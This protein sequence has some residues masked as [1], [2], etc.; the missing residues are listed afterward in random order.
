[1]AM[2]MSVRK[3]GFFIA[4]LAQLVFCLPVLA[5]VHFDDELKDRIDALVTSKVPWTGY[6]PSYSILIDQ[7]GQT[8]Y[9]RNIGYADIGNRIPATHD[10]VY[11]VGSITKS[12][13]ALAILQLVE[14]GQIDLDANISKYL[15]DLQGVSANA[16]V[17]QL[18]TH[19]S[20]ITNYTALPEARSIMTWKVT[21]RDDIVDLF[22]GKALDFEAGTQYSY[23]NSGYYLLGL[24]IESVS[25]QD[26]FEYLQEQVFD[27]L[28]LEATYSGAYDEI[29]PHQARGYVVTEDGFANADPTSK[30]TPFSAGILEASAADLVKYRRAVFNSEATSAELLEL[31]TTTE[32]FPGGIPHRYALGAL[33]KRDFYGHPSWGHSGGI[34]GFTTHHEYFPDDDLTVIVLVNANGAPI[35]PGSLAT[36]MAREIYS[37]PQPEQTTVE[38][39]EQLLASYAGKYQMSPYRHFGEFINVVF[40][41]GLLQLQLSDDENP[42]FMPLSAMPG[43]EFALPIDDEIRLRF[44]SASGQVTGLE[45]IMSGTVSS[46]HRLP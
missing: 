19:S 4:L 9:E 41:D 27:P 23:S 22:E 5:A 24:I 30:L 33:V 46:G 1:M 31:V 38:V 15:A 36:K 26:Y 45:L 3:S 43:N 12:Y 40:K 34:T 35:S 8:V 7:G 25:G 6:T 39:S 21:T 16:T 42:Q 44:V 28:H 32:T 10:T 13:T 14:K 37:I 11:K 29:V 20:G 17:R 18:L 2:L